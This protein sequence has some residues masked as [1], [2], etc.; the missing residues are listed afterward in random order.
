MRLARLG[1]MGVAA[2]A[3]LAWIAAPVASPAGATQHLAAFARAELAHYEAIKPIVFTA[4]DERVAPAQ[5]EVATY[6]LEGV[7][8]TTRARA[9]TFDSRTYVGGRIRGITPVEQTAGPDNAAPATASVADVG[10]DETYGILDAAASDTDAHARAIDLG[11]GVCPRADVDGTR[12]V[13]EAG[14][15]LAGAGVGSGAVDLR[16]GDDGTVD[17]RAAV[18][19]APVEGQDGL[20]VFALARTQLTAIGV[21]GTIALRVIGTPSLQA[22]ATGFAGGARIDWTAPVIE[23]TDAR[24]G[25][26]LARLDAARPE[27]RTTLPPDEPFPFRSYVELRLGA[28]HNEIVLADGT[29]ARAEAELVQIRFTDF[30]GATEQWD[31]RVAGLEAAATAPLGGVTGCDEPA[32]APAA[33][34]LPHA[35]VY[36]GWRT[37]EHLSIRPG[38]VTLADLANTSGAFTVEFTDNA[39][40]LTPEKLAETDLVIWNNTTGSVPWSAEQKALFVRWM[41]CGGGYVGIHSAADANYDWPEYLEIVGAQFASH[42]HTGYW[43]HAGDATLIVE[44]REHPATAPWHAVP[45]FRIADEF[46]KFRANPRDVEGLNVLLSLDETTTYPWV[47]YGVPN[48]LFGQGPY[49]QRQPLAW[50]KTFR[51]AG[52]GFYTN[53]GHNVFTFSRA[54]VREHLLNGIRWVA[55]VRPDAGCVLSG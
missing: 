33:R 29:Y 42:P 36:S 6:G 43:P 48:P 7:D 23:V 22:T 27:Y 25:E 53:L 49:I 18:R 52:R 5:A 38:E 2:A 39:R 15:A 3:A 12:T 41:E 11:A 46:Y 9:E 34:D 50:T 10:R 26:T 37:F 40:F 44:D 32:A 30:T 28:P 20:G 16:N 14:S 21:G 31:L 19:L 55:E 54:D 8:A 24:T 45:S 47:Q 35:V 13:A 51:D 17:S 1:G 4:V